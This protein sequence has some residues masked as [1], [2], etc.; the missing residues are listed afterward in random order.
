[1]LARREERKTWTQCPG[2]GEMPRASGS[3]CSVIPK[4]LQ[5]SIIPLLLQLSQLCD[6]ALGISAWAVVNRAVL[7]SW[8][9]GS[10]SGSSPE[11]AQGGKNPKEVPG[12]HIVGF[13]GSKATCSKILEVLKWVGFSDPLVE[14]M[15]LGA[16]TDYGVL[17]RG[18][19]G[20]SL[21]VLSCTCS[22]AALSKTSHSWFREGSHQ[23]HRG[24]SALILCPS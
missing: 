20:F 11:R 12:V 1:M 7:G 6:P 4:E 18:F 8:N 9:A 10:P 2:R 21:G 23:E 13:G 5:V 3:E 22:S 14:G 19:M 16:L 15:V 17:F 24:G